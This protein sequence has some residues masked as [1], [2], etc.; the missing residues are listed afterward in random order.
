[1][2]NTKNRL[3]ILKGISLLEI[4]ILQTKSNDTRNDYV[5]LDTINNT[6]E[7]KVTTQYK[8]DR[9]IDENDIIWLEYDINSM[10][11]KTPLKLSVRMQSLHP[12]YSHIIQNTYNQMY[13]VK[14]SNI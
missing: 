12:E 8:L 14:L 1:M 4:G 10:D 11:A 13:L 2:K 5:E 6:T 7:K 9:K 3:T